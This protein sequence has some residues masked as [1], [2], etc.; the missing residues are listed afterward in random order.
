MFSN[1]NGQLKPGG[2]ILLILLALA[3]LVAGSTKLREQ[4]F[5][6]AARPQAI[7]A[8]ELKKI[9]GAPQAAPP[10]ATPQAPAQPQAGAT[11]APTT[12]S[13]YKYVGKTAPA[14][15]GQVQSYAYKD[16]TVVFP[17]N[18]W[19]GWAPIIAA[20]NGFKANKDCLFFKEFGFQVDLKLIDD[21]DAARAAFASGQSHVLWGTLDMIALF[22]EGLAKDPR[23][24]PRVFQ[25]V[26]WSNGGDGV[27]V[28][29]HIQSANDLRGKTIVLAQNSPSHYYILRVLAEAGISPGEVNFKFTDTA[30]GAARA[31]VDNSGID[32]CVSWAPDIYNIV[33]EKLGGKKGGVKGARLLTTTKDA[34]NMIADVWAVR[35]DFAADHRD[36]VKGLVIGIFKGMDLAAKDP[37]K[38]AALMADGFGL[39]VEECKSMMGDAHLTNYPENVKFFTN[40]DFAANFDRTWRAASY[41]YKQYGAIGAPVRPEDVKDSSVL[42]EVAALFA[43]AKEAPGPSFPPLQSSKLKIEAEPI[44]TKTVMIQFAPNSADLDANYDK[45]IPQAVEE[46]GR[47]A[48]SFG[49]A[50]VVLEGN[51]DT[52]RKME[53]EREGPRVY[54]EFSKD[55]REL[56]EKRANSVKRALIDKFKFPRE[57]ISAFGNGWDNPISLTDHRQNRRVEVKVFPIESK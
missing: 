15:V 55:V 34:N 54:Q 27:V 30:F 36:V 3:L 40:A 19:G 29:A 31:F 28:R 5:P 45:A 35:S 41:V 17:I 48:A 44:L 14:A 18:I 22:A 39:G 53:I 23:V 46:I 50:R 11:G 12:V 26:D 43:G 7:S 33:D 8:D 21:P 49:A 42:K 13:E 6:E 56:S 38:V 32:A 52:S 9:A 57:K 16:N 2:I 1:R 37:D 4:L 24:F 47:L 25:Q 20:N 51:V 10:A